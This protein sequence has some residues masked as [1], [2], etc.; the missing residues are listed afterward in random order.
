MADTNTTLTPTSNDVDPTAAPATVDPT[1]PVV[2]PN[3]APAPV[4][5]TTSPQDQMDAMVAG[6]G[7]TGTQDFEVV[8]DFSD[9]EESETACLLFRLS[10]LSGNGYTN[11]RPGMIFMRGNAATRDEKTGRLVAIPKVLLVHNT[12]RS[13]WEEYIEP[14][15]A[16]C[17]KPENQGLDLWIEV[18][19][20]N[21][22]GRTLNVQG[23]RSSS[24]TRSTGGNYVGIGEIRKTKR[25]VN[26][27]AIKPAN[28]QVMNRYQYDR[29]V[30]AAGANKTQN[31]VAMAQELDEATVAKMKALNGIL[32]SSEEIMPLT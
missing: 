9:V 31:L 26:Q 2:D 10:N 15:R 13:T 20:D 29:Q 25:V 16:Q 12:P 14:L 22:G 17:L 18:F 7:F 5:P 11:P 30:V 24:T 6:M 19:V 23:G 28:Q 1:V 32:S 21:V 27:L 3:T 4:A 8:E